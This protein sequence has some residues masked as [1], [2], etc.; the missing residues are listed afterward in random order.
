LLGLFFSPEDGK[1]HPS[2]MF[3]DLTG[4]RVFASKL[5]L[6]LKNNEEDMEGRLHILNMS[7]E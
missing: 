7:T 6:Y 1:H 2:K 3:T 5:F 4:Y